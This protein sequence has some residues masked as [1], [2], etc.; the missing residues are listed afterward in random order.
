GGYIFRES[1]QEEANKR[2]QYINII[3]LK[4]KQ[5]HKASRITAFLNTVQAGNFHIVK[6]CPGYFDFM[7]QYTD[8]PGLDHED[9]LDAVAY[10]CDPTIMENVVPV[11]AAMDDYEYFDPQQ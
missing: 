9:A 7:E 10:S 6:D 2:G 11:V 8:Y 5:T 1:L 4:S 3:N